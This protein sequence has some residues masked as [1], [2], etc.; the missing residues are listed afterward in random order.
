HRV[1][2]GFDGQHVERL[3]S[4]HAEASALTDGVVNDAAVRAQ[5]AAFGVFDR[6]GVGAAPLSQLLDHEPGIV[7]VRHEAEI[8][9]L[10]LVPYRE[11]EPLRVTPNLFLGQRAEREARALE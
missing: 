2:L 10:G 11:T 7:A 5:T 1:A 8:L 3:R 4:R 6:S 9:A